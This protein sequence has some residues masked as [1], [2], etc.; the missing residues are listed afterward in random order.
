MK[1]DTIQL[2]EMSTVRTKH[3]PHITMWVT[4]PRGGGKA[5]LR[6][7]SV[8]ADKLLKQLARACAYL[9]EQATAAVYASNFRRSARRPVKRQRRKKKPVLDSR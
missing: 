1:P 6:F 3:E 2:K 7:D 8:E 5:M 4:G 9:E